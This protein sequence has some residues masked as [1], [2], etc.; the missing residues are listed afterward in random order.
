MTN[1]AHLDA[2]PKLVFDRFTRVHE[3][4]NTLFEN[5]GSP[6]INHDNLMPN[7]H[8][9]AIFVPDQRACY[10][11]QPVEPIQFPRI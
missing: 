11:L 9:K 4:E 1:I 3:I 5:Q 6:F 2:I 7:Y 8:M 10:A